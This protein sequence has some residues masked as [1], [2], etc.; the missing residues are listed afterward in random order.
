VLN[1]VSGLATKRARRWPCIRTLRSSPL[2]APP[3][4]ASSC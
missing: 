2:P 1:V 3:A 4:P